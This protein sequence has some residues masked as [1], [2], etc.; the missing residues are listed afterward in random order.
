MADKPELTK[1]FLA[2]V[3]QGYQYTIAHPEESAKIL[4]ANAPELAATRADL[5][6]QGFAAAD[7]PQYASLR[8]NAHL[9]DATGYTRIQ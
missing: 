3:A 9:A 5:L 4:L 1:K 6:L 8:D 2:A 7:A